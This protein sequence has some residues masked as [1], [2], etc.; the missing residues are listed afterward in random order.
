M[1]DPV[2]IKRKIGKIAVSKGDYDSSITYQKFNE[3]CSYGSTFRS[4]IDNNSVPPQ[5]LDADGIPHRINIDKW[6]LISQGTSLSP[7]KG[8]REDI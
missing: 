1:T 7:N 3:V 2:V 6:Q 5:A 8:N 4:K